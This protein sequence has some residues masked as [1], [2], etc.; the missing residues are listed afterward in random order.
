MAQTFG[1]P[2]DTLFNIFIECF[3]HRLFGC[4]TDDKK[5]EDQNQEWT[6]NSNGTI[7]S[8]IS[9]KCME[10]VVEEGRY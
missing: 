4:H 1:I 2:S 10:S 8:V 9:G 7:T 3:Y 6:F 5:P